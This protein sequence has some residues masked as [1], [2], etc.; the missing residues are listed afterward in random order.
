MD[1]TGLN[2]PKLKSLV[3]EKWSSGPEFWPAKVMAMSRVVELEHKLGKRMDAVGGYITCQKNV[4]GKTPTE[5]EDILGFQ[6]GTFSSGVSIWK[7]NALPKPADFELRGYTYLPGGER[8]DGIV[9]R[10]SDLPRPQYLDKGGASSTYPPGLGVEQWELAPGVL[11]PAT[12]LQRVP[13]GTKFTKW[14]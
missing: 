7:L 3:I 8:F 13:F 12:E 2:V 1:T 14:I 6:K 4:R 11:V 10:R 5:M 9:I